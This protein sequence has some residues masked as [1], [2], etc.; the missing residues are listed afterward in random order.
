MIAFIFPGQGA[1]YVG[2]GK[3]LY[4]GFSEAREIFDK[5]QSVLGWDIK[6]RCFDG[7]E[8]MLKMTSICQP[9]ILTVSTAC[10]EVLKP[11]I[12]LA[13]NY[14]AGLSLGEYSALVASG[15]LLF[16]DALRLV[17]R[18]AELMEEAARMYP[19]KM[20]AIIGVDR[21]T[22]KNICLISGK[23]DIA[24]LNCP[25]QVVISGE[26]DAIEKAK[27]IALQKGARKVIDLEVSGA[28]HSS[29]M[30]EAAME[31]NSI[32][33]KQTPFEIPG[34]PVVSN[35]DARPKYKIIQITESL[36]KQIHSPVLWEDSVRFMI[37]QGVKK[38]FEIGPGRVLKGLIRKIDP[39]VEVINIGNK[40]DIIKALS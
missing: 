13:P 29:L 7:P 33:E 22:V 38:F 14:T 9:A 26:K 17:R 19:G 10:L 20:A 28:F 30:W 34:V 15:V 40:D 32:L 21:D 35:V 6:K 8:D 12:N 16:E 4:E 18:R 5:A 3:D 31:F 11:R 25:G 1:Q 37:A 27:E 36:V 23:V 2:M 39:A 24:N